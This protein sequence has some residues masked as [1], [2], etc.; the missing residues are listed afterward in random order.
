MET[1]TLLAAGS[2][3]LLVG[4]MVT[5]GKPK[6]EEDKPK[7]PENKHRKGKK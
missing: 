7:R 2:A 1:G 6:D 5:L 4:A 3:L